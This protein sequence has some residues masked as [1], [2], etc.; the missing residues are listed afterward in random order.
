MITI[1]TLWISHYDRDSGIVIGPAE[2][3]SCFMIEN[4]A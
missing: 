2:C 3:Q 1:F 4:V